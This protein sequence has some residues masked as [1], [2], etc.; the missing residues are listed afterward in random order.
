MWRLRSRGARSACACTDAPH[1]HA[2]TGRS[3]TA[4]ADASASARSH[5]KGARAPLRRRQGEQRVAIVGVSSELRCLGANEPDSACTRAL[6]CGGGP[7][8]G[9]AR[10][11][12]GQAP[13]RE[14]HL[15]HACTA[16]RAPARIPRRRERCAGRCE[17]IQR[18]AAASKAAVHGS[19]THLAPRATRRRNRS[20]PCTVCARGLRACFGTASYGARNGRAVDAPHMRHVSGWA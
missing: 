18:A 10:L 1:S 2:P 12:D 13:R 7:K 20:A 11:F 19:R 3:S 15:R 16:L 17:F 14:R 6:I 9:P 5:G 8:G 4:N